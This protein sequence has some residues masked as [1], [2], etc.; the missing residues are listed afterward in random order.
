MHLRVKTMQCIGLGKFY[1]ISRCLFCM[2]KPLC[3]PKRFFYMNTKQQSEP[4][5]QI[6]F[7]RTNLQVLISNLSVSYLLHQYVHFGLRQ[8]HSTTQFRAIDFSDSQRMDIKLLSSKS[9]KLNSSRNDI[10]M[11]DKMCSISFVFTCIYK[12]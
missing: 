8:F 7:V 10:F 5:Q 12:K 4:L 3:P 11:I 1:E 9:I 2:D 6:V